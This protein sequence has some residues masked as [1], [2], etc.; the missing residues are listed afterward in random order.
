VEQSVNFHHILAQQHV[1]S[2]DSP[3]A[4]G[5]QTRGLRH[6]RRHVY[7]F[8]ELGNGSDY[9]ARYWARTVRQSNTRTVS[10]FS[11]Q[12]GLGQR[13]STNFFR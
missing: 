11:K 12:I 3:R 5:N 1:A 9:T 8:K 7:N 4:F 10:T 2:S 6:T 13:K